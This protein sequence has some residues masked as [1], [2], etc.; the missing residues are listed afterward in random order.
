MTNR[1]TYGIRLIILG[2]CAIATSTSATN[3]TIAADLA[4]GSAQYPDAN[5]VIVRWEQHWTLDKDG[6]L[7]YRDHQWVKLL[8]RRPIGRYADRTIDY[9]DGEDKVIVHVSQAHLA[10]GTVI[11]VPE[12]GQNEGAAP[13]VA[14]WPAF[15]KWQQRIVSFSGI[16]PGTT[17]ELDYEVVTQSGV[18]PCL[19]AE[20][21]LNDAD[22]VHER[23]IV[24]TVPADTVLRA[25]LDGIQGATEAVRAGSPQTHDG[26]TTHTWRFGPVAGVRSEAL[27]PAWQETSPWLRFSTAESPRAWVESWLEAVRSAATID[28]KLAEFAKKTADTAVG[29]RNRIE[30]V[31][32]ALK[33]RFN[34]VSAYEARRSR[35]CRPAGEVFAS[36]YGNDLESAALCL[37]ALRSLE[38]N[39]LP[40]VVVSDH[41]WSPNVPIDAA[42]AGVVIR[43]ATD[44]GDLFI[45]PR[46]GILSNPGDWGKSIVLMSDDKNGLQ[47]TVIQERG[48]QADTSSPALA[49]ASVVDL[50]GQVKIADDGTISG[51]IDIRLTGAH[52]DPAHIQTSTSQKNLIK[53][54]ASRVLD[55]VSIDEFSVTQLSNDVFSAHV[56]IES[57]EPL[58]QLQ[59]HRLM[60]LGAGP[61]IL[62]TASLPLTWSRRESS[63]DLPAAMSETLE[64]RVELPKGWCASG[65]PRNLEPV[66]AAWGSVQQ[67]VRET[68]NSVHLS[69][70]V[71]LTTRRIAA[72]EYAALRDAL[73]LLRAD[74]Y[75]TLLANPCSREAPM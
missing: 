29:Q 12:Y 17:L 64:L 30:A 60:Q 36:N 49:S 24:V 63:V 68:D 16:E 52:Y 20:V 28:D 38:I 58:P 43:A 3:N 74:D 54:I 18:L 34:F 11:P 53:A 40:A 48:N 10:D 61:A 47:Q 73:N 65:L 26:I 55:G 42:L 25:S 6:T 9:R 62:E 13:S 69:R 37:V 23:L 21:R 14:G 33:K 50:K 39:A 45:H 32:S 44:E 41:T 57:K 56:L 19:S 8:N 70:T 1:V 5:A 27:A 46:E 31:V 72:N 67:S 7:R 15:A 2:V 35:Q 59:S 71:Q 51:A 75:R 4:I 22:P 66:T